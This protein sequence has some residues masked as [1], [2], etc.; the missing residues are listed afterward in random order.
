MRRM[1]NRVAPTPP[2]GKPPAPACQGFSLSESLLVLAVGG[3]LSAVAVPPMLGFLDSQKAAAMSSAFLGSLN[4]ARS[5]AIK[6]NGRAVLCKSADGLV[7]STLGGWEQGYILFH[8]ANNNAQV[9]AGEAIVLRQGH[10]ASGPR[11]WGNG[12]VAN[13]VSY[14]ASGGA[15]LVSGAFQAG[16]FTLCPVAPSGTDVRLIVLGASGRARAQRGS[17]SDCD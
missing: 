15:K 12:S 1:T 9:D 7:C 13:Y 11:L 5:E 8:D 14:S 10:V 16:T 4:L 17:V 3:V 6:R 2:R